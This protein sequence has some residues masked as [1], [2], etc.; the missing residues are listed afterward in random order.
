MMED[1][2][3]RRIA[4]PPDSP[5]LRWHKNPRLQMLRGN[6]TLVFCCLCVVVGIFASIYVHLHGST[7]AHYDV[8]LA[9]DAVAS[10]V[11]LRRPPVPVLTHA[12]ASVK[13]DLGGQFRAEWDA[14]RAQLRV[15]WLGCDAQRGATE[16]WSTVAG[17]PFVAAALAEG[18]SV[19][20]HGKCAG[21]LRLPCRA[22]HRPPQTPLDGR[23]VSLCRPSPSPLV[24]SPC[25]HAS[26]LAP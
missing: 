25:A 3:A 24:I 7:A 2:E 1:V 20:R 5:S 15:T 16:L 14:P 13:A 19:E 23:A 6:G 9:R 10:Y 12:L 17:R 26:P 21:S 4:S 8:L 22:A 11:G 18:V